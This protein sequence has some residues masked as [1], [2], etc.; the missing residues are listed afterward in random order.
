MRILILTTDT[1][2]HRK[3]VS[4][5]AK[6][7]DVLSV[8]A[9]PTSNQ[10]GFLTATKTLGVIQE[11][12]EKGCWPDCSDTTMS[13]HSDVLYVSDINHVGAFEAVTRFAAEIT[14]VYGTGVLTAATIQC[15][16]SPVLNL[17]GG[18]PQRY[19]G[20]D[21]HLW[22]LYHG[23]VLGLQVALHHVERT[24]DTGDI[25]DIQ[26]L[27]LTQQVEIEQLRA[28]TTEVS[29][30]MAITAIRRLSESGALERKKQVS[31]GRYY[32]HLPSVLLP[33]CRSNLMKALGRLQVD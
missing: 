31:V 18:D 8:V 32:S 9:E 4:E 7:G 22:A 6:F 16:S 12:F 26:P 3:F 23:D 5:V 28:M 33:R 21:S 29:T 27:S 15:L 13:S 30:Q 10:P 2:H 19:R 24:I 25:V 14:F 1:I 17:H 11:S 20:L